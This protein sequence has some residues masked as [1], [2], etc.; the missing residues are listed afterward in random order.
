MLNIILST[1]YI[2]NYTYSLAVICDTIAV[3]AMFIA[4][5]SLY[6]WNLYK[7]NPAPKQSSK[8]MSNIDRSFKNPKPFFFSK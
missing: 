7:Y 3:N 5:D 4:Y 8:T 1:L 6:L 2:H